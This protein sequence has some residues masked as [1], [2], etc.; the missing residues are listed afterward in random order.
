MFKVVDNYLPASDFSVLK[1]AM[2]SEIFPW[3]LVTK[4]SH[5]SSDRFDYHMGHA[6]YAADYGG[7]INSGNFNVVIPVIEKIKVNSLIRVKANLKFVTNKII[8]SEPHIDQER[9]ECKVAIFY[10]NT[11]NG[12]TMIGDKKVNSVEN[13]IV[14]FNSKLKHYGT[15]CTDQQ[16]RIVINFNY[17]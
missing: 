15:S 2:V 17:F 1:E 11:N 5:T 12:Y 9:F 6:F 16:T 8:K 4:S 10:V 14:F 13:R 7:K 3:Y